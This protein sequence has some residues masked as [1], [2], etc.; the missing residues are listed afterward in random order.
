MNT[1]ATDVVM[2]LAPP[3]GGAI[4]ADVFTSVV[5]ALGTLYPSA[6][7]GNAPDGR[8]GFT[9]HVDPADRAPVDDQTIAAQRQPAD[10]TTPGV[11][12]MGPDMVRLETPEDYAAALATW[13]YGLLSAMG[14]ANYVEQG[15]TGPDGRGIVVTARWRDGLTP[16]EA[17]EQ[18][19]T[20]ARAVT[21]AARSALA[22]GPHGA[23]CPRGEGCTC[24][25]AAL[26]AAVGGD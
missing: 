14:A 24:W 3:P 7:L 25:K 5:R 4:P 13:G 18:A 21:A 10:N 11:V 15:A 1:P 16:H 9:V 20:R 6:R 2:H 23:G 22:E 26:S 19:E 17:R 12:E 8:D